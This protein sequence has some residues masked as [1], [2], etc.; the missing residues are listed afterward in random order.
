MLLLVGAFQMITVPMLTQVV[1][2]SGHRAGS[3][4]RDRL[5]V[6]EFADDLDAE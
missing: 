4:R 3:W 2:R 6:D 5:V 1:S